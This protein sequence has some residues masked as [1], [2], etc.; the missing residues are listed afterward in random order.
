MTADFEKAAKALDGIVSFGAVD[1]TTD[2]EAGAPYG[3]AGFPTLKFFGGPN[4]NVPITY[5]KERNA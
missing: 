5:E 1:M 3:I 4:R 2:K